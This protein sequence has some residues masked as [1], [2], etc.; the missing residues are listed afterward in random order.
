MCNNMFLASNRSLPELA[1]NEQAPGLHIWPLL[2]SERNAAEWLTLPYMYSVGTHIGCGC[3]FVF[4][5][6]WDALS[7]D[8]LEEF[9]ENRPNFTQL[10][11]YLASALQQGAHLELYNAD[12]DWISPLTSAT[13]HIETLL[14]ARFVFDERQF[15]KATDRHNN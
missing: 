12:E 6:E 11:G 13:L 1:F 3:P 2:P 9:D 15:F 10:A 8:D 7:D 14:R 5:P 4:V